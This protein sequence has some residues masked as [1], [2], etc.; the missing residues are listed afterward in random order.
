MKVI[1]LLLSCLLLPCIVLGQEAEQEPIDSIRQMEATIVNAKTREPLG[2]ATIYVNPYLST[3]ANE[4]G[5]FSLS[6]HV[7]DTLHISYVG[8]KPIHIPVAQ[9]DSII[10][11]EPGG[12]VLAEVVVYSP[13]AIIGRAL[14]RLRKEHRFHSKHRADFFFRQLQRTNHRCSSLQEAFLSARSAF[15]V[16]DMTLITG[17][18]L[19]HHERLNNPMNAYRLTQPEVYS[20]DKKNAQMAPISKWHRAY[21]NSTS[22]TITDGEREFYVVHF[23]P[24]DTNAVSVEADV[25]IDA[26]T[27]QIVRYTGH[28]RNWFVRYSKKTDDEEQE[29]PVQVNTDDALSQLL[30]QTAYKRRQL[31]RIP[32]KYTFDLFYQDDQ[33][34]L[35]VKTVN[36]H[37]S[38]RM[39][40]KPSEVRGSLINVGKFL[41][42][43]YGEPLGLQGNLRREIKARGYDSNFWKEN[44]TIKRTPLEEEALDLFERENLEGEYEE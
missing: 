28:F 31:V 4:V 40:D 36:F 30:Y 5:G 10:P 34:F 33:K 17:R 27:F 12:R 38:F 8:F 15:S 16:K 6:A 19:A 3:I 14:S 7:A 22:T 37:T 42:G 41:R 43:A 35:E 13:D 25:Y 9:V 20:K 11:M 2:F 32:M 39:E 26:R 24:R 18:Y 21:Y 23:S 1:K 29:E 44:E